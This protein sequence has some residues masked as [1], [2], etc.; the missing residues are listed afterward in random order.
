MLGAGYN[1][2]GGLN[3]STWTDIIGIAAGT[4]HSVGLKKDGTVVATGDNEQTQLN[5]ST[6][7]DVKKI[8]A[9]WYHTVA[10]KNDGT[11][12]ATGLDTYG[13]LAVSTWTD[14]VDI[15]TSKCYTMG[16]KSDGTLVGCGE[17]SFDRLGTTK[18]PGAKKIT[19]GTNHAVILTSNNTVVCLGSNY[20]EQ[21]SF[22]GE[23]D[24][25]DIA[26]TEDMTI[27]VKADGTLKYKGYNN[28]FNYSNLTT[29]TGIVK[30]A[31]GLGNVLGLKADGAVVQLGTT[32][33][34]QGNGAGWDLN[35]EM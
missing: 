12:V 10:L 14:I 25:I 3:V 24:I 35:P 28:G 34:G 9:D 21:S 20:S 16:I 26:A 15:C 1:G 13:Q 11:V 32:E 6:W 18:Y 33:Q 31:A 27:L 23:M 7:T 19:V 4:L 22:S 30:V 17:M 5:V 2:S 29:W 8:V